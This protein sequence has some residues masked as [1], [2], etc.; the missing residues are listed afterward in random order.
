MDWSSFGKFIN[1]DRGVLGNL[2]AGLAMGW[3]TQGQSQGEYIPMSNW[4]GNGLARTRLQYIPNDSYVNPFDALNAGFAQRRRSQQQQDT[5]NDARD[6]LINSFNKSTDKSLYG[7]QNVYGKLA[8]L[9]TDQYGM[10]KPGVAGNIGNFFHNQWGN[11]INKRFGNKGD[12]DVGS[13]YT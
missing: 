3:G 7:L 1:N 12:L 8:G 4:A 6:R 11:I 10:R 9:G 5:N 2:G 13:M